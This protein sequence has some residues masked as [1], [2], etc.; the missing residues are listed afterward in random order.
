ML[1][2]AHVWLVRPSENIAWKIQK[3]QDAPVTPDVRERNAVMSVLSEE[4]KAGVI[5]KKDV[6]CLMLN[7]VNKQKLT[8]FYLT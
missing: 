1:G 2:V 8:I 7:A 5:I 6:E 3:H 4:L